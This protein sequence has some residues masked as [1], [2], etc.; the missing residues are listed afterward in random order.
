MSDTI[1][2]RAAIFDLD[3]TLLDTLEDI[4]DSMNYILRANEFPTHPVEAYKLYIGDG[5]R[6]L[7]IRALPPQARDD[8]TI[9]QNLRAFRE[10][11]GQNWDQKSKP[12]P[13]IPDLLNTL[14]NRRIR[15]AVLSNKPD[16]FT[17][18]CVSKLL[19]NWDFELAIG[20]GAGLPAKPDPAGATLIAKQ[21]DLKPEECCF[22]GDTNVDMETAKAAGMF[23]VGVLWGFRGRAELESS[24]AKAIIST[25]TEAL[26][27]FPA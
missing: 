26:K 17:Q 6:N 15:L 2:H 7:I 23:G 5:A 1:T 14:T 16:E 20:L 9:E 8:Q 10:Q 11:Y 24:G 12:Y 21:L 25:P 19:S 27:Y 22:F 4:A 18:A 13:G 3:G